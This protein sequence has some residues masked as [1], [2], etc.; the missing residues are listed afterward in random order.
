MNGR[1]LTLVSLNLNI[2][3]Y[4]HIIEPQWNPAVEDQAVARALRLGQT[5]QITIF[6]YII[7]GTVEEVSCHTHDVLYLQLLINNRTLSP[8]NYERRS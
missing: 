2:A 4:V 1:I 7:Q 6:R 8:I 5:K 3:S